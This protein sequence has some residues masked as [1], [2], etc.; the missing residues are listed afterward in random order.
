MEDQGVL[1]TIWNKEATRLLSLFGWN[2][3]GDYDMDVQGKDD[4]QYGIDTLIT[5]KTPLKNNKQI[6][7]LEA[8]RYETK[9]F[10]KSLLQGWI[11]RLDKK[12]IELRN[13]EKFQERFPDL[14][15]CSTLE[16]GRASCRERV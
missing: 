10:N 13:S 15:E 9:N 4:K 14:S 11:E 1:G 2:T 8:K 7:I 5:F 16:I 12:L 6:A 3:I